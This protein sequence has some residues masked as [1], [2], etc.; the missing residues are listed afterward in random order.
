MSG[1]HVIR[2][3]T[4]RRTVE[5]AI[6]FILERVEIHR[7]EMALQVGE[8]LFKH[9]FDSDVRRLRRSHPGKE[10]S[11]QAI[12]ADPRVPLDDDQL[13]MCIHAYLAYIQ[14]RRH[15]RIAPTFSAWKMGRLF[16]PLYDHP[17]QLVQV[18]TWI[19]HN[20]IPRRILRPV[21]ALIGP[22]LASGGDLDDLLVTD[23]PG[24]PPD[25]PYARIKRM[26]TI[27]PHHIHTMPPD[28]RPRA[29]ALI[30]EIIA[31]LRS[32]PVTPTR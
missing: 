3:R 28:L 6:R 10:E 29:I 7:T 4:D 5:Q 14:H 9:I 24:P 25:T 32:R 23:P 16:G 20:D 2:R 18:V 1:P 22:Y 21:L 27:I 17:R 13:Y 26:L 31:S 8:Y 30:D 15:S 12:A 11:I 19:E